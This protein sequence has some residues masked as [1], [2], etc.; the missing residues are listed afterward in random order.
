MKAVASV[1]QDRLILTCSGL[2]APELQLRV[3]WRGTGAIRC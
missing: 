3:A 2:G 1:G